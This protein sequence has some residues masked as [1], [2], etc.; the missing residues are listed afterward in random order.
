[1]LAGRGFAKGMSLGL[2]AG[3]GF[4]KRKG[5]MAANGEGVSF[6][7]SDFFGAGVSPTEGV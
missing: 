6:G 7:H 3:M 1:M 2:L 4:A 5:F